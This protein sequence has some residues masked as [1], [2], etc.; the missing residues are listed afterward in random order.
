MKLSRA[1]IIA[2]GRDDLLVPLQ[3][4]VDR[5][6]VAKTVLQRFFAPGADENAIVV[7][8]GYEH[9]FR[10]S[11]GTVASRLVLVP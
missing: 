3:R 8:P 7:R 6:G 2:A 5:H 1:V 10:S 4:L 11:A 9:A